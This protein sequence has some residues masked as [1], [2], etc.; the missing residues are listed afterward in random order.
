MSKAAK[1]YPILVKKIFSLFLLA[2]VYNN[3]RTQIYNKVV[4]GNPLINIFKQML[5]SVYTDVAA[6]IP[7]STIQSIYN[8]QKSVKGGALVSLN[9][10]IF[11]VVVYK[12]LKEIVLKFRKNENNKNE[13]L[14]KAEFFLKNAKYK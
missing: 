6:L 14:K 10:I 8:H 7:T 2:K 13:I 12:I 11:V 5:S 9:F 1:L 4:F 3:Y